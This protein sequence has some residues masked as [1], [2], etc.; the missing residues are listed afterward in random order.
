MT[1]AVRVVPWIIVFALAAAGLSAP[2]LGP[3]LFGLSAE[4]NAAL[5]GA[6]GGA[7]LGAAGALVAMLIVDWRQR[8]AAADALSERK[9]NAEKLITAELVNAAFAM[10]AT[11]RNLEE[12]LED[13]N[14][15]VT[16]PTTKHFGRDMPRAMPLTDGLGADLLIL[17]SEA[18]DALVTLKS[19]MAR[20]GEAMEEVTSGRR[21]YGGWVAGQL[22]AALRHDMSV[23]AECFD[24][25]APTRKFKLAVGSKPE[26]A[27][28]ALRRFAERDAARDETG[29]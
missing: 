10:I 2:A 1:Q 7:L 16:L 8:A 23:L 28:E 22:S 4:N 5:S 3:K 25:F 11:K 6:L 21:P 19:N 17:D 20:S 27:S 13:A 26:L 12:D 18:I 24:K 15:G 29:F 14:R 9:R